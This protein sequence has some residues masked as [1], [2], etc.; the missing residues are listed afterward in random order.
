MKHAVGYIRV[1]GKRQVEEGGSLITQEKQVKQ[2]AESNGYILERIFIEKGESAKTDDRTE[3][4]EMLRFCS[5]QKGR[6]S[7]VIFPKIDRFARNRDDYGKLKFYLLKFGIK[8]ASIGEPIEDTPVG[9]FTESMFASMAQLDNEIRSERCNDGIIDA[10][11]AGRWVWQPP[12][13]YQ[14]VRF[15]GK[16]TIEP[17]PGDSDVIRK[18]FELLASGVCSPEWIRQWLKEQGVTIGRSSIFRLIRN[19]V[20]ARRRPASPA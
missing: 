17:K 3:L 15:N 5:K 16:G 1:S 11:K 12:K 9:R 13:G 8:L 2:Y 14:A 18:A 20:C 6:I 19:K 10:T 4:K 7:L